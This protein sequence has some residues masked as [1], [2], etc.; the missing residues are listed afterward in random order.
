MAT[1]NWWTMSLTQD[2]LPEKHIEFL[3]VVLSGQDPNQ[4]NV[5]RHAV[6]Y[7]QLVWAYA[8]MLQMESENF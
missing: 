1:I 3:N 8:V 5:K 2:Q 4:R 7:T 6:W